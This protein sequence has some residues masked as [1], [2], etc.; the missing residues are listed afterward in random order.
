MNILIT[1]PVD[2]SLRALGYY[3]ALGDVNRMAPETSL[4]EAV[5]TA[6]VLVLRLKYFIGREV[7]DQAANLKYIITPTTGLDHIDHEYAAARGIKI[8]SLKGETEFLD[9]I[10][11][12]AEHTW[13]LLLALARNLPDA[14]A[15]V[16]LGNWN[17]Q[18][19]RGHNLADKKIGL[20]GVGRVGRQVAR[21][22]QAFGMK[23]TGFDPF[24][25]RWP[26]GVERIE[27]IGAFLSSV[28]ILSIHIPLQGNELFFTRELMMLLPQ[29][30]WII[31]TS[32]GGVWDESALADLLRSG[33]I[34]AIAT[35]VLDGE[36]DD[37]WVRGPL[38]EAAKEGFK[39]LI[40]PHIGGATIESMHATEDFVARKFTEAM[41]EASG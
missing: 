28:D 32:R 24:Q 31:N 30:C 38:M 15:D 6:E 27:Q 18:A 39:V 29:G 10:P 21:F 40:T 19:F 11:S 41:A 25:Q 17:R 23:V 12:T 20:L 26:D 4:S 7:M 3:A 14:V 2:Y 37:S 35:D 33:R 9:A 13:A 36:L 22:A 34:G 16:K 8:I 1:E 5:R